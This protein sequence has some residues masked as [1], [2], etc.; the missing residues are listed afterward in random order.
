MN[1][2]RSENI[3]TNLFGAAFE[4][5]RDNRAGI[6]PARFGVYSIYGSGL[7]CDG[8]LA[9]VVCQFLV[10]VIPGIFA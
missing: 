4:G 10:L 1:L 6:I 9:V 2:R 3:D 8:S 7:Y 5:Q